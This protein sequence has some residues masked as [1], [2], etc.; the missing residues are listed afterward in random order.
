MDRATFEAYVVE[1][2][3][4]VPDELA[5]LVTNCVFL[6]ED[7]PPADQP[8]DL[9]GLYEGTPITERHSDGVGVI[10]PDRI[11]VYRNP[12]LAVCDTEDDVIDEVNVTVVHEIAHYFGIDDEHLHELGYG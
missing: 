12:T 2:I 11:T 3:D 7:D 6:V 5:R 1:A 8:A 10:F 4:L 9:L